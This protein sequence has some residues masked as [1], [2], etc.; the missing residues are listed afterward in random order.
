M[1]RLFLEKYFPASRV[2]NIRK[3]IC[4]VRQHNG[5]SLHEYW[6]RFKKLCASCPHHQIS[7]QLLIQYFYK[8]L[9]P[10]DRSM[11]DATSGG[12]L[13]D[14]TPETVRNLILN[15]A[16]NSQQF[17][18]RLDPPSKHVNEVNISSLEQQIA[19]LTSLVCQMVGNMQ[20]VKTCGICSVV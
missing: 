19:S 12:D 8:G 6:E 13:V 10:T 5:E 15:M 4:G 17:G 2:A 18:T 9:L 14:K 16:A 7:E 20:M 3:E 11:F 1:K